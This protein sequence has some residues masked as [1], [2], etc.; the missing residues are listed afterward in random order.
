M[1]RADDAVD[2]IA[3]CE[4]EAKCLKAVGRICM[5]HRDKRCNE[6]RAAK[7]R[8]HSFHIQPSG[9]MYQKPGEVEEL[10]FLT[11]PYSSGAQDRTFVVSVHHANA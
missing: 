4:S 2:G 10:L 6:E 3:A 8:E 9:E 5:G 11:S 1:A 7:P